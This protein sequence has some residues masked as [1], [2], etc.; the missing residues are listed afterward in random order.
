MDT[1]VKSHIEPIMAS[2]IVVSNGLQPSRIVL[3]CKDNEYVTHM[4]C[5][6]TQ[7]SADG[8]SCEFKHESF[9]NGEYFSYKTDSRPFCQATKT[10][11]LNCA[12]ADYK[13]RV[14]RLF[15]IAE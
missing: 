7:A 6:S 10:E 3:Y 5:L 9:Y 11:A 2:P 8:S 15:D 4:E 14:R 12:I 1:R 13:E